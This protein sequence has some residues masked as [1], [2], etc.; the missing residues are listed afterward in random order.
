M[1]FFLASIIFVFGPSCGG[2]STLSKALIQELGLSWSYLD[3]DELIENNCCTEEGADELIEKTILSFQS[4]NRNLIVDTQIPWRRANQENE[5]YVLVYAPLPKLLERD[6][7]R[8]ALLQRSTKRA[9]YARTYVEK[10]FAEVFQTPTSLGFDYDLIL[11]SSRCSIHTE[12][13]E[14]LNKISLLGG[15]RSL[16]CRDYDGPL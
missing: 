14:V 11:D 2:K 13:Q 3:C 9:Y 1:L 4:Q 8:A 15:G 12:I 5:L 10:T 16:E 7:K 6:A